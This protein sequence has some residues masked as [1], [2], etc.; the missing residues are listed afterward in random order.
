MLEPNLKMFVPQ[1]MKEKLFLN[2]NDQTYQ[3][4]LIQEQKLTPNP[5]PAEPGR[6]RHVD[7]EH[8]QTT[9][10]YHA[11]IAYRAV[12]WTHGKSYHLSADHRHDILS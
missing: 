5:S 1:Q 2:V 4:A 12:I 8:W 11:K 9:E 6:D 10:R 7:S 3:V